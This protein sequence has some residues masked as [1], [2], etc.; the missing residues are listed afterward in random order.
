MAFPC[1][2]MLRPESFLIA[3][4]LSA[5]LTV[6]AAAQA[7]CGSMSQC[8]APPPFE[9]GLRQELSTAGIN[10]LLGGVTAVATR[11][12]QGE[13]VD[14]AFWKGSLGGAVVYAGKRVAVEGFDGA[15]LAGRQLAS[16]GGSIVR[17]AAAGR[18]PLDELVL[19]VGPLRLYVSRTGGITPRLDM[20]TVIASA[21]FVL[22]YDARLDLSQSLSSGAMVFRATTPMPGLTS[23]GALVLWE[24]GDIPDSEGPRLFA[25]ERV[26]I[27]Q[28]DQAFLSWDEGIE[29]WLVDRSAMDGGFLDYLDFGALTLGLRSGL[30]FTV[31]YPDR[32][33]EKEAYFLAQSAH[34][35]PANA[36]AHTH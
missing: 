26:H 18:G 1:F 15:G 17:N 21:G 19:P 27:L 23:A 14:G 13:P 33:W 35:L 6:G 28:Y 32:P 10:A 24:D 20:A 30:A 11:L 9:T 29:R 3:V 16:V 4:G 34:P 2:I 25:H 22:A 8:T 5:S 36:A 12:V 31:N 7:S